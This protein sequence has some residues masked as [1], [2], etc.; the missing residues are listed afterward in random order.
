MGGKREKNKPQSSF[1]IDEVGGMSVEAVSASWNGAKALFDF[2][3]VDATLS[4]LLKYA[5]RKLALWMF[6]LGGFLLLALAFLTTVESIHI[7]NLESETVSDII[8]APAQAVGLEILLP[9]LVYQFILYAVLSLPINLAH[10]GAVFLLVRA[11]G[12]TG[13]LDTQLYMSSVVWLA[14]SMSLA[15]TLL[16]PLYCLAAVALASMVIV[17]MLYLMI[18]VGSKSYALV[19]GIS[20]AHAA[21]LNILLTIPK[22]VLWAFLTNELA[23]LLGLPALLQAGV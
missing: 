11:T 6:V 9:V 18:Y 23:A 14:V 16:Q 7:A 4:G 17:S 20:P 10:E 5:N 21:A 3:K 1:R 12:G 8:G 19:H 13:K 2:G 15:V 22:L